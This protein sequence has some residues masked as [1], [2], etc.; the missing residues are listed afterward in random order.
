MLKFTIAAA[1]LALA[2][3][4]E[5]P[6]TLPPPDQ[7]PPGTDPIETPNDEEMGPETDP[8]IP[9]TPAPDDTPEGDEIDPTGQDI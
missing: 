7:T 6:E 5:R 9:P 2:A 4:C 8:V 1:A 3:G